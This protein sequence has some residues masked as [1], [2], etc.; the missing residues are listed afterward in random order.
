[1]I[2]DPTGVSFQ[3]SVQ[4]LVSSPF[5]DFL[6]PGI[7]LLAV[8]GGSSLLALLLVF[9]K[10]R[11]QYAWSLFAA[12][13]LGGWILVQAILIRQFSWFQVLYLSIASAELVLIFLLLRKKNDMLKAGAG[14]TD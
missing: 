5:H 8:V 13:M 6:V 10:S 1:M 14:D 11:S 4:L 3:L 12:L 9:F 2:K 7:V